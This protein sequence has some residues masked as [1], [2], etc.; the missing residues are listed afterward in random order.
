[1]NNDWLWDKNFTGEKA[2]EI[3]KNEEDPAFVK[4]AATLLLR[5]NSAKDIFSSYLDPVVFYK[6]WNRIKKAM[7]KDS[8]GNPRI[9]YWQAIF[10]NLNE[11]YKDKGIVLRK[12]KIEISEACRSVGDRIKNER[13]ANHM[14]QRQF[15][16]KAG[17][18]QQMLS[19]IEKG[20]NNV[21]ISTLEKIADK[22]GLKIHFDLKP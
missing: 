19:K 16:K 12:A 4:M 8:W 2:A 1:M 18:S 17:I 7:R 10:R 14:T 15:S 13:L 22:F 20:R 5:N 6:N 3:L 9:D 11:K 21:S